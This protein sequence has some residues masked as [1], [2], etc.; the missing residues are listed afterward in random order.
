MEL[1][2]LI[3]FLVVGLLVGWSAY[4]LLQGERGVREA[5]LLGVLGA[6]MAGVLVNFVGASVTMVIFGSGAIALCGSVL[7]LSLSRVFRRAE[8]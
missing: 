4:A 3:I 8:T 5:L 6:L 7:L 2:S 1:E